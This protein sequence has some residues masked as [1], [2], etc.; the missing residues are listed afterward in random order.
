MHRR[1]SG[2]RVMRG[3]TG[4]S[5]E[6]TEAT[7]ARF[8]TVRL[9]PPGEPIPVAILRSRAIRASPNRRFR[10]AV[11]LGLRP[12]RVPSSLPWRHSQQVRPLDAPD[13]CGFAIPVRVGHGCIAGCFLRRVRCPTATAS[14]PS[15]SRVGRRRRG[16]R[17][18]LRARSPQLLSR[19]PTHAGCSTAARPRA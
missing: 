11:G 1:G 6:S 8:G 18:A 3:A 2:D 17:H 15:R 16:D 19:G 14:G 9:G 10:R 12:R 13:P 7:G 4:S 5:A